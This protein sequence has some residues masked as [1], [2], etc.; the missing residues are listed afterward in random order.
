L[1]LAEQ[2]QD[3]GTGRPSSV[4]CWTGWGCFG[5]RSSSCCCGL[6]CYQRDTWLLRRC[7]HKHWNASQQ[8]SL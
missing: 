5:P 8:D 2:N 6:G 1:I 3:W 7:T 4:S